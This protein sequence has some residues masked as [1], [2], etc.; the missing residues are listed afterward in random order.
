LVCAIGHKASPRRALAA[1][2]S[3]ALA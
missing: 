3:S 1:S 2:G